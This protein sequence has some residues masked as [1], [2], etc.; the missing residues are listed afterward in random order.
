MVGAGMSR[1][2]IA[3]ALGVSKGTIDNDVTGQKLD[4]SGQKLATQRQ[5]REEQNKA[6]LAKPRQS[7]T[8]TDGLHQGDFCEL[9]LAA[10]MSRRSGRSFQ[11]RRSPC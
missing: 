1:R 5:Q 8:L 11:F 7:G 9:R 3:K 10:H 6:E 4:E 2:Q